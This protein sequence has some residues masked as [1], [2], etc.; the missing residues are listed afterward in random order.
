[1][2]SRVYFAEG[3]GS[4]HA[5]EQVR[6]DNSAGGYSPNLAI[7]G[8]IVT[9]RHRLVNK[10]DQPGVTSYL[11]TSGGHAVTCAGGYWHVPK[12]DLV[13]AVA[14]CLEGRWLQIAPTLHLAPVLNG[15][16]VITAAC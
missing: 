8:E 4:P 1:M 14:A 15:L 16:V 7:S 5:V 13:G 10:K 6:G 3:I 9:S 11:V 12:V 2:Q